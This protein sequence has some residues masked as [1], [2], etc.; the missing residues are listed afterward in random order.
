MKTE[1]FYKAKENLNVAQWCF[2]KGFY[3]ACANRAYYAVLQASIAAL[4]DKGITRDKIDHKWVQ[5]EFS[6]KLIH[7]RKIYPAKLKSYLP[8]MQSIRNYADYSDENVTRK[9][10]FEQL[11]MAKEMLSL[12]EKELK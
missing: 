7:S 1:F 3:D 4:A 6:S 11:S 12:I 2:D 5:A 8:E 9:K 10:A